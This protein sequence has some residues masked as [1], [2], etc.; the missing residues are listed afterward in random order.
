MFSNHTGDFWIPLTTSCALTNALRRSTAADFKSPRAA[1]RHIRW[2]VA[3]SLWLKCPIYLPNF[4]LLCL[5]CCEQPYLKIVR[6]K[7]WSA[8][9][10]GSDVHFLLMGWDKWTIDHHQARQYIHAYWIHC[11]RDIHIY[12]YMYKYYIICILTYIYIYSHTHTYIYIYE[13]WGIGNIDLQTIVD[14]WL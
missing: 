4:F 3:P 1:Q 13:P 7:W 12:I 14:N 10:R 2:R 9:P 5:G 8:E 11:F 6:K